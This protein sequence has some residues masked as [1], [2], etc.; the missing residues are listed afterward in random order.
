LKGLGEAVSR[1]LEQWP[2]DSHKQCYE[3]LATELES[4]LSTAGNDENVRRT[5]VERW[6]EKV[7]LIEFGATWKEDL[8]LDDIDDNPAP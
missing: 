1:I 4:L 8:N 2:R 6:L 7:M 3:A 5:A